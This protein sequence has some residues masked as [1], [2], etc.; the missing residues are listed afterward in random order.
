M[1]DHEKQG[2]GPKGRFAPQ[3]HGF[4]VEKV[5]PA[6]LG[7]ADARV[8]HAERI[9]EMLR[10]ADAEY[11]KTPG[12]KQALAKFLEE[13][14]NL[15]PKVNLSEVGGSRRTRRRR[16]KKVTGSRRHRR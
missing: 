15:T 5:G 13:E 9:A 8:T 3:T 6:E 14:R 16:G 4:K 12:Y 10:K 2:R 1:G 11:R 7:K